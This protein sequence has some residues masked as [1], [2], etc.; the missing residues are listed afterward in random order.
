MDLLYLW[1]ILFHYSSTAKS[2]IVPLKLFSFHI[3]WSTHSEVH[4]ILKISPMA[5]SFNPIQPGSSSK[6]CERPSKNP[7]QAPWWG[8][9]H[10]HSSYW[11]LSSFTGIL[12]VEAATYVFVWC[13]PRLFW[14]VAMPGWL[15]TTP[16][17]ASGLGYLRPIL[18]RWYLKDAFLLFTLLTACL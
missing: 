14:P 6:A 1:S 18:L 11:S 4:L 7:F 10:L 12:L 16:C 17:C 3:V 9:H 13:G 2:V 5:V 8:F 15:F